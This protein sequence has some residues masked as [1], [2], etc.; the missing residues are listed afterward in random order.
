MKTLRALI[1]CGIIF[2][3]LTI[4]HVKTTNII[5]SSLKNN[6]YH[7]LASSSFTQNWSDQNL[8]TTNDDWTSV[9]S[10]EGYRGDGLTNTYDVDPQT[11]LDP[12]ILGI[13]DVNASIKVSPSSFTNYGVTE[14]DYQIESIALGA[15]NTA[16]APYVKI[17][18]NSLT[19]S[20]I[21]V[22]YNV[23]DIENSPD[24]AIQQVALHFRT[25]GTGNFINVA[26]A[27]IPDATLPNSA[28]LVTPVDVYLPDIADNQAH[29]EIRIMTT[30]GIDF[31]EWIGI[32]D[33]EISGTCNEPNEEPI[34]SECPKEIMTYEGD[35]FI[36]QF[37]ASD[38]DGIV[39]FAEVKGE[40]PTGILISDISAAT[41]VGGKLIGNLSISADTEGG[42]HEIDIEFSN[43]DP[44][45][46]KANCIIPILVIP[47]VC[48]LTDTHEIG[49]IQGD[50]LISPYY[51][52]SGIRVSGNVTAK[53]FD[54]EINGFY[55]QDPT[56][57]SNPLTSDG[58]FINSTDYAVEVGQS[59]QITGTVNES[60]GRTEIINVTYLEYCGTY[61]LINP[62]S[63]SLPVTK[64]DDFEKNESMLVN[65]SDN[66]FINGHHNYGRYGEL[67]LGSQPHI[68][69]TSLF[70]PGSNEYEYLK[71]SNILD[72]IIL[73][74]A[75][76][77]LFPVPSRHPNGDF[78]TLE[79]Y[80]RTGD[81]LKNVTGILDYS[82]GSYRIIP[83]KGANYLTINLRSPLPN[84]IGT[85]LTI[86]SFNVMNYFT[87]L[88]SRG[89]ENEI[90]FIRQNEKIISTITK[91]NA[92]IL[93]LVEIENNNTAI[94]N[95]VDE[96]N[97][98]LGEEIYSFI[99]TGLIGIDEIKV[100]I[101]YKKASVNPIGTFAILDST[102]DE[103]FIDEKNRPSL[104][105][106]FADPI[107]N[108]KF[109]VFLN[110]FKSRSSTC[111]DINDP[112]LNDGS[113]NCNL[114]RKLAAEALVDWITKDPT[115]SESNNFIIIGDLNS[116]YKEEPIQSIIS[117]PD[118]S[119]G[120]F[121]DY[122]DLI[123]TYL[124]ENAYTYV[125]DSQF[126]YLD[127]ALAN[128]FL[129]QHVKGVSI[130][131]INADETSLLDY[132]LE[133]KDPILYS[134]DEIRSSDHD[135]IIIGLDFSNDVPPL[136]LTKENI[137]VHEDESIEI[138]LNALDEFNRAL[139]FL[140]VS[141]PSFGS[142]QIN[143]NFVTYTPDENYSGSD[144][145][146]FLANN[147][148]VDSNEGTISINVLP[149]NDTPI[150]LNDFYE[151]DQNELLI[152][153][154]SG[155]LVNDFDIEK[156]NLSAFLVNLPE[157]GN[158]DFSQN[159]SF[160]Y[161]PIND[162]AGEIKFSYK[163]FDGFDFSSEAFVTIKIN[164]INTVNEHKIYVPLIIR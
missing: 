138:N 119:Q 23:K 75:K 95:L 124:G 49:E 6:S 71:I 151:I 154:A 163:V 37:S 100:A 64:L 84:D 91:I 73:D 70:T 89:A 160:S 120:T 161:L 158:L 46:Q 102:I 7:L 41:S 42:K 63:I 115:N 52:Y 90:E 62:L 164:K 54:G 55:I 97:L 74:D 107:N 24:N 45:P 93:G 159:G 35:A 143:S 66:L 139:T 72:Q 19:C 99:D 1:L 122:Y 116:Y 125:Y 76:L 10:I 79:N 30:N 47:K 121:D 126:G 69:P 111:D 136:A 101:I 51:N 86:S 8:I 80:F 48:L 132:Q 11:I 109:T 108:K 59:V 85:S 25:G 27:Y 82:F 141:K 88:G 92:D 2:S 110:H 28:T 153:P 61:N 137:L 13:L 149:T 112:D 155:V 150:A 32:D 83:T 5:A 3:I 87:T 50:N 142:V 130:W 162:F 135:P 129:Y 68:N 39:T 14:F 31:D 157:H 96:L 123:Q 34:I 57:D 77:K 152:V 12:D 26:P 56:G 128:N 118:N 146:K 15:S 4:L 22:K 58:I 20:N 117:G 148:I 21:R 113:G 105:Q 53:F 140:I 94:Q 81:V 38:Q 106:T 145:F 67:I 43:N 65:F 33:I 144:S 131:H 156:D 98:T 40:I 18:L 114:T 147:G 78:F 29:L 9:P 60:Y 133:N 16:D 127:H 36:S 104:A 17:H 103:R 134:P 44:I